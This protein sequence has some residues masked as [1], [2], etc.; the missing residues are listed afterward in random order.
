M[1][2]ESS[3]VGI[4]GAPIVSEIDSR[5][6]MAYAAALGDAMPCYMDTNRTVLAHPMFPVCFEW[7]VQVAMRAQFEKSSTLTRDEAMRAVHATH[8]TVLYRPIRPPERLTT[9]LTVVGVQ[10]LTP[11]AYMV[12]RLDTVD[13]AGKPVCTSWYGALYRGVEVTGPDIAPTLPPAPAQPIVKQAEPRSECRVEVPV[14]MAHIYT[15]CA[16]IFNPIHTDASVARAAGLPSIIL[17]G[18]ATLA[19]AVSRIIESEA[20]NDPARIERVAGRFGA[21][22]TMPSTLTVRVLGR[23]DSADRAAVFF[24]TLS[25]DGG[26]AIR[27][28]L[29]VLRA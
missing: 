1:P 28:G 25:G 29:V 17:H 5:W 20:S 4:T 16:R 22:V 2:L 23:D 10:R 6:T 15:E 18:T 19:L 14:G 26:L 12:T 24:E 7:P 13:R 3:I 21:M 8:D 11:G 9:Q 27:E